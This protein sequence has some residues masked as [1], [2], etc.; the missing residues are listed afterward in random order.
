MAR[1]IRSWVAAI[2]LGITLPFAFRAAA[3]PPRGVKPASSARP[4]L[5]GE[6]GAPPTTESAAA[7]LVRARAAIET[8]R[9]RLTGSLQPS[10]RAKLQEPIRQAAQ[11]AAN[12]ATMPADLMGVASRAVTKAFASASKAET[13]ALALITLMEAEK[14][15]RTELIEIQTRQEAVKQAKDCRS[16]LSCLERLGGK[17]GTSKEIAEKAIDDIKNQRDSL[18]ELGD[19]DSQRAKK[20]MDRSEKL[21][22][23]LSSVLKKIAATS[24]T[25]T[26]N[27]K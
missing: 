26:Q 20:A 11:A 2:A 3:E 15:A 19:M 10:V 8:H 18:R 17:G 24:E 25:V 14:D 16:E 9:A 6:P 13:D 5:S 21:L 1:H 12:K 22:S 23:A 7:D 4:A 27:L